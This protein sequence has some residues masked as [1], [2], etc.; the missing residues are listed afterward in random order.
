MQ[1]EQVQLQGIEFPVTVRE[2]GASVELLKLSE[3]NF[4]KKVE[5]WIVQNHFSSAGKWGLISQATTRQEIVLLSLSFRKVLRTGYSISNGRLTKKQEETTEPEMGE[6]HFRRDGLIELYSVSP[7]LRILLLKP[8]REALGDSVKQLLLSKESML[9]LMK[10]ATEVSSVSLGGM[11][12]PFFSEMTLSGSD[13]ANSRTFKEMLSA[14][15]IKAFRGR[16]PIDQ[17]HDVSGEAGRIGSILVTVQSN[18]K[19]R[20]F[21]S[22]RNPLLQAS[23]EDFLTKVSEFAS[24]DAEES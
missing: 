23:V 10:E 3:P 22:G 15:T 20:F 5:A 24:N 14:G 6:L 9:S 21:A 2:E 4:D 17:G 8:L 19:V 16:F 1:R 7:K 13:P 12:N 18:C 11:G